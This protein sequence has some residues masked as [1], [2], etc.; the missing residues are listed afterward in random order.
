S[1]VRA[2]Q[3]GAVVVAREEKAEEEDRDSV[4]AVGDNDRGL[5][6]GD[7]GKDW[8]TAAEG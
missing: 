3:R 5:A 6:G 4:G 8:A 7:S 2:L 1:K